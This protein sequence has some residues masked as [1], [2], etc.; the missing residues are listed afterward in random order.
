MQI[1]QPS[2]SNLLFIRINLKTLIFAKTALKETI[3]E[4][5]VSNE[6]KLKINR[7]IAFLHLSEFHSL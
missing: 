7:A 5:C 6:E 1:Y 3:N 2:K 4:K